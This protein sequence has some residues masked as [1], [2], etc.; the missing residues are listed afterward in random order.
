MDKKG[1][2][3]ASV[4]RHADAALH[5]RKRL[6]GMG[7]RI[8]AEPGFESNTVTGFV[9]ESTE[10]AK[11]IKDRLLTE[12]DVNIVGCRGVYKDN[13]LRI[14]HMANFEMSWLDRCL[15]SIEKIIKK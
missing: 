4:K 1:G 10:Q 8:V 9:C 11:E 5:V 14:A 6:G 7:F 13:G 12:F 2:V 3:D 15:D